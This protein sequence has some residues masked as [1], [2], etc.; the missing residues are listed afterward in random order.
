M[1][2]RLVRGSAWAYDH[3]A[4]VYQRARPGYPPAVVDHAAATLGLTPASCIVEVGAGTGKF[5][6]ALTAAGLAPVALEP[7]AGMAAELHRSLPGVPLARSVAE[8]LPVGDGVADAV[9]AA[10]AFH[11]FDR[12]LAG[13]EFRRVLRPRG[14][15]ALSWQVRDESAWPWGPIGAVLDRHRDGHPSSAA[16]VD[17]VEDL[18]GFAPFTR[19]STPHPDTRPPREVVDR[20]LSVSFIAALAEGERAAVAAEVA[21]IVA[22]RPGPVTLQYDVV[23]FT[24]QRV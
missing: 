14:G 22:E 18:P 21:A 23:V 6:R 13:G 8:R 20:V 11:W 15:I 1:T 24:A 5:T 16:I 19:W 2:E 17:A 10:A 4:P 3:A 12:D 7:V 9:I